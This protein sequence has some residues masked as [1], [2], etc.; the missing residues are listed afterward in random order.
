MRIVAHVDMD[1]F[2][3][4]VEERYRPELR[5]R[6][7]VTGADPKAGQGRGVVTTANYAARRYGIR[8]ALPISRAW[9][10]AEDARRRGEPAVVFLRG[11]HALYRE[12]SQR[13]MAILGV[14]AD[15]FEQASIDEA[16]L[17]L[18]SLGEIARAEAHARLLKAEIL[19]REGL[20]CSVGIAPNK[21][22]AKIASDFRK[23]DG[24]TVVPPDDVLAFLDPLPVRRLPGIGP[25]GEAFLHGKQAQTIADLRRLDPGQLAKWFGKWGDELYR[26]AR[27]ISDSPVSSRRERKSVGE[28]ET[29]E[30]DT[31]DPAFVCGRAR[32]LAATVFHRLLASGGRAFRTVTVT[33]RFADFVTLSRSHTVRIPVSSAAMLEAEALRLLAAFFDDREN[34][35]RK[36]IRLI[37]VRAEKL[38]REPSSPAALPLLES[39]GPTGARLPDA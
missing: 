11:D 7:I 10:L 28:Q 32:E 22:V 30:Q 33:V 8:S 13:I 35:R 19:E 15:S 18:S 5:G 20:T 6:P 37:G 31:L 4:A 2:F 24:L 3:A 29:F 14:G 17:E 34:P 1:A 39:G 26:K 25:K 21:L 16:Y 9:R 12:V 23:P 38:V 36:P 27:G